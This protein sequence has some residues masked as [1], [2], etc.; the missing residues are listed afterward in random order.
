MWAK[1]FFSLKAV[2]EINSQIKRLPKQ[3]GNFK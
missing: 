2:H 3:G 1:I